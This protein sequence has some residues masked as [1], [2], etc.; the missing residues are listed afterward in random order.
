MDLVANSWLGAFVLRE[1][2]FPD[3]S[4]SGG[5]RTNWAS[6]PTTN[7]VKTPREIMVLD[8]PLIVVPEASVV[9]KNR[10][11]QEVRGASSTGLMPNPA[12]TMP[13]MTPVRSGGNHLMEAGVVAE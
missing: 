8:I 1:A 3:V 5:F 9:S 11:N 4:P 6:S 12:T 2:L 13:A 10:S 7:Q